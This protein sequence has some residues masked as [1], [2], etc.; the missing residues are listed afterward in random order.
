MTMILEHILGAVTDPWI[1]AP[2]HRLEHQD[3]VETVTLSREDMSRKRLRACT[4]KG[5]EVA[6][7]LDRA[8]ALFDGAVML[9]DDRAA[10]VLRME[11]EEW[12]CLRPRD[13]TEAISVGFFAGNLHWRVRFG[14]GQLQVAL[15]RER[16]VYL[17]RLADRLADGRITLIDGDQP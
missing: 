2:L 17:E 12:L 11:P 8:S 16:A 1:A 7:A 9:L 3:A 10:I 6:I 13:L 14:D 5:T 15:E 4:D